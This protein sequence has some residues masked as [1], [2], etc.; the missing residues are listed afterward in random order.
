MKGTWSSLNIFYYASVRN[1]EELYVR[2]IFPSE[3]SS[4][5]IALSDPLE[6]SN[7]QVASPP[8]RPPGGQDRTFRKIRKGSEQQDSVEE[9][10]TTTRKE[11]LLD[12]G[13]L[14]IELAHSRPLHRL[15]NEKEVENGDTRATRIAAANRLAESVSALS[16]KKYKIVVKKCLSYHFTR[17]RA[18]FFEEFYEDVVQPL[19]EIEE[20]AR[21]LQ[22]DA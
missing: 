14:L 9:G 18:G 16:T 11:F 8:L 12:L 5:P 15:F 22:N 17:E 13:I 2:K 19:Q 6:R 7:F 10:L 3:Y 21:V 1:L 4:T 20:K